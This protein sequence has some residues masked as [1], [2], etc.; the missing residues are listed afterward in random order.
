MAE[1]T[2]FVF[3][4][5]G[6]ADE[7]EEGADGLDGDVPFTLDHLEGWRWL[8]VGGLR[9]MGLGEGG[10]THAEDHA[11]WE[12]DAPGEGLDYDVRP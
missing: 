6:L 1:G 3:V 4:A 9:W 10:E 2:G 12:D 7:G 8:E 5:E 11:G